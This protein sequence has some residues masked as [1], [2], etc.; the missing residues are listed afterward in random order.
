M[1]KETID[2]FI[3]AKKE[4]ILSDISHLVGFHSI[5]G[6]TMQ[7]KACLQYFLKRAEDF[8]FR[9]MNTSNWDVGIVE[10]GEGDETLGILVHVDVVGIG[11]IDKW[12][13]DPFECVRRDGFL[14]GRG[15]QDDKG[16]AVMSL[17]ALK[18]VKDLGLPMHRKVWLIVG[19]SEESVWTD[20]A[21]FKREFPQPNF[22]FS[23][24]GQFPIYNIEKGYADLVLEFKQDGKR[25]LRH[26]Q[27]GESPNTIPSKAEITLKD[28]QT[29]V[30]NGISSHSSLPEEGDNAIIKLCNEL[31]KKGDI[32]LDFVKFV[33]GFIQNDGRARNLQ[34]DDENDSL[35]GEYIGLTTIAPTVIALQNDAVQLTLNIRQKFGTTRE[36]ILNAITAYA[37]EFHYEFSVLDYLDPMRVSRR[38]PFLKVMGEVSEEYGID[39]SF[40]HARGTSYAKSMGNFVSWGPVLPEDPETAHMEDERISIKTV[41]LASKLY[42]RFIERMVVVENV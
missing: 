5:N 26:L 22:G 35:D 23:P 24:D 2:A 38:L 4:E 34:I 32:E 36:M 28:G 3:E 10:M 1:I 27:G 31:R 9:T 8:G 30:V 13:N 37:D 25:G 20:I 41:I 42:A 7:T 18:A 21:S 39:S 29:I 11:D 40:R 17:Y 14:W 6:Q 15:V 33:A 12:T 19:T 16:A